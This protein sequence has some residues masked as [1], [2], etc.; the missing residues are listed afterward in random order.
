M[1]NYNIFFSSFSH[2]QSSTW[3]K[4]SNYINWN[5]QVK[6][7]DV[8]FYVD[9]NSI[10][11]GIENKNDGKIKYLWHLESPI[12]NTNFIKIIEDNLDEVLDTY[13]KKPN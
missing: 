5:H 8:S 4:K 10:L 13:I 9:Q 6:D 1:N 7:N 3:Y 12:I 11:N 2:A